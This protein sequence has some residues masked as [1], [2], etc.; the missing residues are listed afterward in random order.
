MSR[1]GPLPVPTR[2]ED[3]RLVLEPWSIA[4]HHQGKEL[5]KLD[6]HELS[7]VSEEKLAQLVG[8]AIVRAWKSTHDQWRG[9]YR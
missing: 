8:D 9:P 5:F 6:I 7:S 4:L 3:F 2:G 1:G